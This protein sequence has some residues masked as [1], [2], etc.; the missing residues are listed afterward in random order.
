[1]TDSPSWARLLE[2]LAATAATAAKRR[3]LP[4]VKGPPAIVAG[5]SATHPQLSALRVIPAL[6]IQGDQARP[7]TSTVTMSTSGYFW[8]RTELA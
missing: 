4:A 3:I 1:M 7:A 6:R 5:R 8:W 2:A